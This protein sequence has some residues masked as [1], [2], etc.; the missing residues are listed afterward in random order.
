MKHLKRLLL[1]AS[2]GSALALVFILVG[3]LRVGFRAAHGGHVVFDGFLPMAAWYVSGFAVAG[4]LVGLLFPLT[5]YRP[6][7][8][9]LGI[10]AAACFMGAIGIADSGAPATWSHNTFIGWAGLSIAFGLACGLGLDRGTTATGGAALGIGT[11]K[12]DLLQTELRDRLHSG[13]VA[14]GFVIELE[15]ENP[16]S[17]GS[18]YR[19]Y[20]RNG[21]RVR[22]AWDGKDSRFVLQEGKAFQTLVIKRPRELVGHGFDEFLDHVELSNKNR[23][24]SE[25]SAPRAV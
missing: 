16:E 4:S 11:S 2:L 15:K 24:R 3:L 20:V 8:Y 18:W 17:F 21:Q 9:V 22:L 13:L 6:L 10:L 12:G 1:G 7:R 19:E 5:R 23:E 25:N 14:R